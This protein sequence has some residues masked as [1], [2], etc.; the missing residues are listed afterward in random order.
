MAEL[1][2]PTIPV[3]SLSSER[4]HTL[5]SA[6]LRLSQSVACSCRLR[7]KTILDENFFRF[8]LKFRINPSFGSIRRV[9]LCDL[10][11]EVLFVSFESHLWL[12][13]VQ[14]D[15]VLRLSVHS[16]LS[17]FEIRSLWV[18]I[19]EN[20]TERYSNDWFWVLYSEIGRIQLIQS[21][22]IPVKSERYLV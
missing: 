11:D 1:G 17:K 12:L 2:I 14:N 8:N 22:T 15:T 21:L 18:F 10:Y 9:S 16:A 6:L 20:W 13:W 7:N 4:L 5:Y 19:L 3:N